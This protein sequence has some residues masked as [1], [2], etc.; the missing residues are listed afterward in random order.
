M[1][2][3]ADL[4]PAKALVADVGLHEGRVGTLQHVIILFTPSS[5]H[6]PRSPTCLLRLFL[7]VSPTSTCAPRLLTASIVTMT[8]ERTMLL[9]S[10][11]E[12]ELKGRR[13]P[14]SPHVL[15]QHL[16]TW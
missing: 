3:E 14:V 13:A 8:K 9:P 15:W 4:P 16:V 7:L 5:L 2:A 11:S 1:R 10:S 6:P 12:T